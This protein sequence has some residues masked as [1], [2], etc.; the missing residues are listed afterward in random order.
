MYTVVLL[1]V[2]GAALGSLAM[3]KPFKVDILRDR[4]SLVKETDAGLLENAYIIKII[5]TTERDQEFKISVDGMPDLKLESDSKHLRVKATE[6]ES[7]GVRVQADPQV[8]TKGSHEI[9]FKVE[10]VS[11]PVLHVEEKSSFIGE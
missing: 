8:A 10:T 11:S 2:L 4:A 5:N 7:F 1:I 6:T 9:H 3:R